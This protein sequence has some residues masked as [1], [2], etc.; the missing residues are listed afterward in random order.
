MRSGVPASPRKSPGTDGTK[1]SISS[2]ADSRPGEKRAAPSSPK[3]SLDRCDRSIERRLLRSPEGDA[4]IDAL[5]R[6]LQGTRTGARGV[7][8]EEILN[9]LLRRCIA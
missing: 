4:S 7:R 6:T 5:E 2:T 9:V 3:S 1:T 8:G